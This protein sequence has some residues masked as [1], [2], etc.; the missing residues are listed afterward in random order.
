MDVLRLLRE[1][2][3][4]RER[5]RGARRRVEWEKK[6]EYS[7]GV[8]YFNLAQLQFEVGEVLEAAAMAY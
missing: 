3:R 4:E 6:E 1:S 7:L 8:R 5:E 2:R